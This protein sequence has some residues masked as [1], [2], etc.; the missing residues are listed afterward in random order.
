MPRL[1]IVGPEEAVRACQAA[2]QLTCRRV[3]RVSC[4]ADVDL[5]LKRNMFFQNSMARVFH[6]SGIFRREI[7]HITCCLF[8]ITG[9]VVIF[10]FLY[11]EILNLC[12]RTAKIFE[13]FSLLFPLLA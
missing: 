2:F 7:L 9:P 11:F 13:C 4:H 3:S 5:E 6:S 1:S 8:A 10:E 12:T